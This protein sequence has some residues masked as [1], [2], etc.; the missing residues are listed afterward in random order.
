MKWISFKEN[1]KIGTVYSNDRADSDVNSVNARQSVCVQ[2]DK[3]LSKRKET[4]LKR[5]APRVRPNDKETW[6]CF[7]SSEKKNSC[8][9]KRRGVYEVDPVTS[10]HIQDLLRRDGYHWNRCELLQ[11]SCKSKSL[12]TSEILS[13]F[14]PSFKIC[15]N[16]FRKKNY[17]PSWSTCIS[18]SKNKSFTLRAI[19][20]LLKTFHRTNPTTTSFLV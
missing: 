10:I 9:E 2:E 7:I 13:V 17:H 4:S 20:I 19:G 14:N 5:L 3:W 12:A 6:H 15:A 1:W 8:T 16:K 18:W 11:S